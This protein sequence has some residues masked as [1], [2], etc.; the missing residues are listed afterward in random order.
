MTDP[1]KEQIRELKATI[2]GLLIFAN[3]QVGITPE[4][5]KSLYEEIGTLVLNL[6]HIKMNKYNSPHFEWIPFNGYN[7]R[8]RRAM[9]LR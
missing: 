7:R 3:N 1:R 5:K 6:E 9:G 2:N 4:N 8:A